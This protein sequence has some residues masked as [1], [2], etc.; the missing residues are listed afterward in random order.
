MLLTGRFP[1]KRQVPRFSAYRHIDN[2]FAHIFSCSLHQEKEHMPVCMLITCRYA[3]MLNM[4]HKCCEAINLQ[5][6]VPEFWIF[7]SSN[8]NTIN[9]LIFNDI[10]RDWFRQ[11]TTHN[12]FKHVGS[13]SIL[14]FFNQVRVDDSRN[15]TGTPGEFERESVGERV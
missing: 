14:Y 13:A 6:V 2:S 1:D 5:M 4:T 15:R 11:Q 8:R 7:R 9:L 10:G 12:A 3:T